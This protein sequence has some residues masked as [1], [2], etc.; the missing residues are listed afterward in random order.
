MIRQTIM[1]LKLIFILIGCTLHAS[2]MA[3]Q[4]FPFED[5]IRAFQHQDSIRFPAQNSILFIGSSS[6]RLWEDLEQRFP[7]QQIIK[8]GVGGCEMADLTNYYAP[9]ILI[10]YHPRKVFIFAGENDIS[11]GKTAQ[12][13]ADNFAKLWVQIIRK[14]PATEIY[15]LSIKRSPSGIKYEPIVLQANS[16]IKNYLAGKAKSHY[17][18]LAPAIYKPGTTRSDSTLFADDYLHLNSKGYDKWQQALRPFV[19]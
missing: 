1:K 14:L 10:P 9:L 15:F 16:L 18:D 11:H 5:E 2:V 4:T 19:N 7:V 6:I 13:V 3:Q 17:V 12:S 8:R